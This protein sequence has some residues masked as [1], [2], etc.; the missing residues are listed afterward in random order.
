MSRQKAKN[1]VVLLVAGASLV[2]AMLFDA[3]A[4][5]LVSTAGVLVLRPR[6]ARAAVVSRVADAA[7]RPADE[8]DAKAS[9]DTSPDACIV[10]SEDA[11]I[12]W[13]NRAAREQMGDRVDRQ[14]D[15]VRAARAGTCARGGAGAAL[16]ALGAGAL[17]GEGAHPALTT[18][19]S[20]PR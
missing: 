3:A 15:L 10:I 18:R 4:M 16:R 14:P 11:T 7:P 20:S 2:S 17:V 9:L 6:A 5:A 13:V 1:G 8:A 19:R 12:L